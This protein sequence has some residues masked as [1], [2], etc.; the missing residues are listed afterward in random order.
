MKL[1]LIISLSIATVILAPVSHA[2]TLNQHRSMVN[3]PPLNANMAALD[4]DSIQTR[5][6]ALIDGL[7]TK[8]SAQQSHISASSVLSAEQK[9][10]ILENLSEEATTL[11][12]A[13]ETVV[14]A[15]TFAELREAMSTVRTL[16]QNRAQFVKE[17][18]TTMLAKGKERAESIE[19]KEQQVI[20]RI[21]AALKKLESLGVDTADLE[22]QLAAHTTAVATF[23]S[24]TFTSLKEMKAAT[25][26]LREQVKEML[27][28]IETLASSAT[29]IM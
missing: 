25:V 4:V 28:T 5:Q 20:I 10:V 19:K 14:A 7:L 15:T 9:A 11:A 27:Q 1:F 18:N 24:T 16:M 21:H 2:R 6:L 29:G 8:N 23:Q 17:Q 13:R 12:H 3:R 26:E 22:S